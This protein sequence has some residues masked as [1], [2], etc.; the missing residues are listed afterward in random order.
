MISIGDL[1][2][3]QTS[4]RVWRADREINLSKTEFEILCLMAKHTGDVLDHS[5]IYPEI[6]GSGFEPQSKNLAVYIG[7]LRRKIE[8]PNE[9]QL[10]QTVRG[11]SDMSWNQYEA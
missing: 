10:L 1:T 8:Q 7:Y 2:I 4:S 9:S 6:W 5:I 11:R 3:D